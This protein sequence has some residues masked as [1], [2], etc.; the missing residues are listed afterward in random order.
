M[1]DTHTGSILKTLEG[2]YRNG[3]ME[4][5]EP[6][7]V[8]RNFTAFMS[9]ASIPDCEMHHYRAADCEMRHYRTIGAVYHAQLPGQSHLNL[10]LWQ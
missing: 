6:Q 3:K 10:K 2:I 5:V 1:P 4:F 9:L 7:L 8:P